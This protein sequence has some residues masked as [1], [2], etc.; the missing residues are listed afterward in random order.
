M[1]DVVLIEKPLDEALDREDMLKLIEMIELD[2]KD[3]AFIPFEVQG[4]CSA[5]MGLISLAAA[6]QIDYAYDQGTELYTFIQDIL[7][8]VEKEAENGEYVFE[9]KTSLKNAAI[10]I[11]IMR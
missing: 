7:E 8:D 3:V 9:L 11:K 6:E 10:N 5:A 1:I 4:E 2:K